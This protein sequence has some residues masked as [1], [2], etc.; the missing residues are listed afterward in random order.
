MKT[1]YQIALYA[2]LCIT[3]ACKKS[4]NEAPVTKPKLK[5]LTQIIAVQG[6]TN[7]FTNYA[8]DDN[9]RPSTIKKG[10]ITTAFYYNGDILTS[11]EIIAAGNGDHISRDV[12]ELNYTEGQLQTISTKSYVDGNLVKEISTGYVYNG[13]KLTEKHVNGT[14]TYFSYDTGNNLIKT[15]S[16][17]QIINYT[18]DKMKNKFS[19]LNPALKN[20][21]L[22]INQTDFFSP[23][24]VV[25]VNNSAG[26][27][28]GTF[29]YNYDS[30]GYPTGATL[31]YSKNTNSNSK[32]TYVYTEF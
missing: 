25:T 9:K 29:T 2:A 1:K 15:E 6:G 12:N 24:N 16:S 8:F 14:V 27:D 28:T 32:F 5:Y 26:N 21:G 10:N 17:G 7:Y 18:Y 31:E 3:L 11:Y 19:N 20:I 22:Q 30:D 23:N 4:N 13:N